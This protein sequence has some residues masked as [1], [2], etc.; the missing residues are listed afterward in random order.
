MIF[1]FSF[2]AFFWRPCISKCSSHSLKDMN[3]VQAVTLYLDSSSTRTH[4][5]A[6]G[7]GGTVRQEPHGSSPF[8]NRIS[9]SMQSWDRRVSLVIRSCLTLCD[10]MDCS[11]PGFSVHGIFQAR[12]LEWVAI[13][14]SRGSS[15]PR[16]RTQVSCIAGRFFTD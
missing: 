13:S 16:D 10:P 6:A 14:Y 11:P 7:A 4:H 2:L 12:I 5:P 9:V 1:C 3:V 15:Q 8:L